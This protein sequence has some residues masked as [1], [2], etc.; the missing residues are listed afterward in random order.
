MTIFLLC[1]FLHYFYVIS[2]TLQSQMY[3]N[4]AHAYRS[5]RMRCASIF[6]GSLY[7]HELKDCTLISKT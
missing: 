5:V 4:R 6:L 1:F 2:W 3:V 7:V